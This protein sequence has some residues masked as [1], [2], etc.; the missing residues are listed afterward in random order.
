MKVCIG[1][2]GIGSDYTAN[3]KRFAKNGLGC[4]EV[5]FTHSIYMKNNK[6]AKAVGEAAKKHKIDL[7]VHCPYYINLISADKMKIGA[8]KKRIITSAERGHHMGADYVV[9]H[10]GF[11]Q[12]MDRKDVAE[13][14]A[15]QI[16]KIQDVIKEKGWKINLAPELTGKA[17]QFG[18]V[19]ELMWLVKKTNCYFCVD[20][21]HE[22]ARNVGKIDYP[23]LF[24]KLKDF[25]HLHCHFSGIEFG[26]KGEKRHQVVEKGFFIPLAQELLKW[27]ALGGGEEQRTAT[28][29]SESPVTWEDS[30]KMK[31]WLG[32]MS[33]N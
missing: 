24:E 1:P 22:F 25:K 18:S 29:I 15:E 16:G 6:I 30:V 23:G 33:P 8:S 2:G 7:S 17:S 28:I 14:I 21:A 20:F 13:K 26:P 31:G 9:F 27:E 3:F 32:E 19:D 11:F 4:A 12:D 5:E 10:S